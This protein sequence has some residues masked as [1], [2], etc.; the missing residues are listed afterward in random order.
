M[1][2]DTLFDTKT[3]IDNIS[4]QYYHQK[5]CIPHLFFHL[6][7]FLFGGFRIFYLDLRLYCLDFDFIVWISEIWQF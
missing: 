1:L 5:L 3:R 2:F 4:V 6:K 7:A